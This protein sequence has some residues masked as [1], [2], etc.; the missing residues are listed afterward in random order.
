LK[1]LSWPSIDY[2]SRRAVIPFWTANASRYEIGSSML[3][4][5]DIVE[6]KI[7]AALERGEFADLPGQGRPLDLASD[8]LVPEELRVPYRILKNSGFVPPQLETRSE[9]YDLEQLIRGMDAGPERS[10]ALRKL[11]LLNSQLTASR[12]D[13]RNL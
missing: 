11:H 10:K 13:D 3:R 9:I 12:R 8:T 6:Q 4:F 5:E 7:R 2:A 1:L